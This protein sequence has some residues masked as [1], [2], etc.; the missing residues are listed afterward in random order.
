MKFFNY[1][2]LVILKIMKI[3]IMKHFC[4]MTLSNV[5]IIYFKRIIYYFFNWTFIIFRNAN[6]VKY[7][8]SIFQQLLY[9]LIQ[10]RFK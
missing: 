5:K 10:E 2:I 1:I 3:T 4:N 6:N 8:L 9:S 7:L